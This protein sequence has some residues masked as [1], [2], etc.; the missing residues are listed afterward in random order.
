MSSLGVS[1]RFSSGSSEDRKGHS[2][3][4]KLLEDKKLLENQT[5]GESFEESWR[6]SVS[7]RKVLSND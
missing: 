4:T 7:R 1:W 3:L 6:V 5:Q 2:E